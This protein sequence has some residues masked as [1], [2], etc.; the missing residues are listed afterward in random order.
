MA[1][2]IPLPKLQQDI[3]E[4][5]KLW[6]CAEAGDS[7]LEYLQLFQRVHSGG[8]GHA[9]QS[10]NTILLEALEQLTTRHKVEAELLRRRFLDGVMMHTVANQLNLGE[11]TT[12]RKQQEAIRLLA[13]VVQEREAQARAE[14]QAHLEKRLMLPPETQLF[15]VET[16]LHHLQE[17]LL[18]AESGWILSIEG[19]GGIG[20]T[21]L[22]N[23]L[24]RQP[25]L[26]GRFQQFAWVSAKQHDFL[27][28]LKREQQTQ[29][30]LTADALIEALFEQLAAP[31]TLGQSLQRKQTHL[32][33][34]LKDKPHLI[35]IDNL[36]TIPD[37][38][39]LL[40]TLH[41]LAN[42]SKF[43][44]TSRYSLQAQPD[45]F[46]CNSDELNPV[47]TL[48]FIRHEAK[49]RGLSLLVNAAETDLNRIY[50]V[51]GGNPLALKL[52]IG[53]VSVLPLE[54]VLNN[55]KQ[56]RGKKVQA[57][58]TFIYWHAW[59]MLDPDSQQ[60]LLVMPLTQGA[61]LE[62]LLALSQLEL[63]DLNEALEKL[64]ALSLVQVRGDLETRRYAIHRLTETFLLQE[65]VKWQPSV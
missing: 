58:Y 11:S 18:S 16:Q 21:A 65:V 56:A 3:H 10:A 1:A 24:I 38:Q 40:P 27:S 4:A 25:E 34:L 47:D 51:V 32:T 31:L 20:K 2:K 37:Y 42:P 29:P 62:Q 12:Y 59:H 53:Q 43:L 8:N 49:M 26:A 54:Q 19:L 61:T 41:R 6:H 7:P 9:R 39:A 48:R 13:L 17:R 52:V 5:L 35:V 63:A 15:G 36:E 50:D 46:C 44:L 64:V 28:G 57:L 55:L 45:I 33:Q 14:Y 30:A 60:V 23:A 22:A